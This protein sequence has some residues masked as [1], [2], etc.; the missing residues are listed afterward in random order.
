MKVIEKNILYFLGFW[1]IVCFFSSSILTITCTL[2]IV[3]P[4]SPGN[5]YIDKLPNVFFNTSSFILLSGAIN[6]N[7]FRKLTELNKVEEDKED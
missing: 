1:G 3:V 7:V 5:K 4:N 6:Y 2:Y